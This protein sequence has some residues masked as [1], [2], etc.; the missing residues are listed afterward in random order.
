MN[1]ASQ[2][3]TLEMGF[4]LS[5]ELFL[6]TFTNVNAT[7]AR[8]VSELGRLAKRRACRDGMNWGEFSTIRRV[9]QKVPG[10]Q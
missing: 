6:Q 10:G 8:Y 4:Q 5:C 3:T 7:T 1:S 9:R 2:H